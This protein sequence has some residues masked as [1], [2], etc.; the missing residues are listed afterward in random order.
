MASEYAMRSAGILLS[1]VRAPPSAPWPEITLLWTSYYTNTR[2]YFVET[3]L[4]TRVAPKSHSF[5]TEDV[6][7]HKLTPLLVTRSLPKF[8]RCSAAYLLP[9]GAQTHT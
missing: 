6:A 9:G 4:K 1:R 2:P 3:L 8:L 5:I 7:P